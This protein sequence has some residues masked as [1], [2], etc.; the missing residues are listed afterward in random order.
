MIYNK[1]QPKLKAVWMNGV[2]LIK[3]NWNVIIQKQRIG[4]KFIGKFGWS[5][6]GLQIK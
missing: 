6:C 4:Y 5:D 2:I 3:E 1:V